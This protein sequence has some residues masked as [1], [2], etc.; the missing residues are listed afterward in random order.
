MN[1]TIIAGT[2][3]G[4]LSLPVWAAE[5]PAGTRLLPPEQQTYVTN[6]GTEPTTIDPQLVEE[7]AGS[8]VVNDLFEG[9]YVLD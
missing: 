2:V 5:V 3:A 8:A 9:L 6:I 7:S 4:L 1:K